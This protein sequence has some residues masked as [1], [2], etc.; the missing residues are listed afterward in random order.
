MAERGGLFHCRKKSAISVRSGCFPIYPA[1]S[2]MHMFLRHKRKTAAKRE[3]NARPPDIRQ[4]RRKGESC[5]QLREDCKAPRGP[6]HIYKRNQNSA[7]KEALPRNRRQRRQSRWHETDTT[8]NS[9][10]RSTCNYSGT[11]YNAA[12]QEYK[13]WGRGGS[14]EE[15]PDCRSFA[16]DPHQ[17]AG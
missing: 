15:L 14:S 13:R 16:I 3:T 5:R 1:L 6:L 11:T 12:V 7:R 4:P 9:L 17:L 8:A 10:S 2:R